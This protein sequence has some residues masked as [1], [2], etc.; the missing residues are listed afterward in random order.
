MITRAA[1]VAVDNK[2]CKLKVRIPRLDGVTAEKN[3]TKDIDLSWASI[4]QVPG[5]RVDY[6]EEDIVV[7]GFEDNDLGKP[8]VLGHLLTA[9]EAPK[10]SLYGTFKQ[11]TVS[12]SF[13]API[14][15]NIGVTSYDLINKVTEEAKDEEATK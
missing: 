14:N 8:I 13:E 1:V 11:L 10:S 9:N 12:E 5:L 3:S 15:T 2:N 6:R 4:L 7:V